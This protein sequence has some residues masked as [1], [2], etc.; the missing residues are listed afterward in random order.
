MKPEDKQEQY[1]NKQIR[2]ARSGEFPEHKDIAE[3]ENGSMVND[4]EDLV[5]LGE[6]MEG[7]AT[8][9]EDKKDGLK[10]DPGQ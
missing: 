7:M 2:D 9:R 1:V 5:Q 10:P 3:A 6:D 8:N 4:M